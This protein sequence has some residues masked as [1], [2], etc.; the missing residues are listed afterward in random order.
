MRRSV[1]QRS[2]R[3]QPDPPR[4]EFE[5]STSKATRGTK[6]TKKTPAGRAVRIHGGQRPA[7]PVAPN[8]IL[9]IVVFFVAL[10]VFV[11]FVV[12]TQAGGYT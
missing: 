12:K 2:V 6:D 5:S 8:A 9:V 1:I 10:R 7:L 3:L 4:L 11:L